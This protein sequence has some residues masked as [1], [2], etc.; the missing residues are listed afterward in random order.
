MKNYF[1]KGVALRPARPADASDISRLLRLAFGFDERRAT[2]YVV[3]AGD[4]TF[5]IVDE[6]HGTPVAC[7]ALL[8]TSHTFAGGEVPS[9]SIAHVAIAP[10]ARGTGLA[11]PFMS[12]LCDAARDRGAAMVSLFA[13]ARPVY[14]KCGFELAGSEM[15]YEAD[16]SVVPVRSDAAFEALD[17]RDPRILAAYRRKALAGAG[18]I[19]REAVHWAELLR[20]PTD[21]LATFGF[22]GADLDAYVI[23]DA[24][25]EACLQVRD[26]FAADGAAATAILA[27]L[28]RFR[29]V[30]PVTRWHGGPQD[31]L[32]GAMPDKGWRLVHQEEWLA[33]VVEPAAALAAR[34]YL[35]ERATLAIRLTGPEGANAAPLILDIEDGTGRVTEGGREGLPTVT[36]QRA[37]FARLF[38]GF[39][40]ATALARQGVLSGDDRALRTCDLAFAGPAPWVAEHF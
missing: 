6:G 4:G 8:N 38:T 24:Q 22:G 34:R 5:F 11:R 10:E 7:A 28:G 9:A 26:W 3:H 29:S 40:S 15:V 1:K 14:R 32:A 27:F 21:G 25:G 20:P 18:L 12:A 16:L 31:D 39:R 17:P 35:P 37:A 30:Y 13:S 19:T 36:V 23:L 2:E 33:N